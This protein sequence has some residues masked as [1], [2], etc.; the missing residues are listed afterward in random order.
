VKGEGKDKLSLL[1]G[2]VAEAP[3]GPGVY[4]MRDGEGKV[5]YVG[6]AKDLRA[7]LRSYLGADTRPMIPFLVSRVRDVDF[8]VTATEKE[9]LILENN[10]IK[11]HRPRYNIDF[12]DD[13]AYF[14]IRI[15]PS[16]HVPSLRLQRRPKKDGARYF[17]PYPSSAA[18]KEALDFLQQA[19]GLRVCSDRELRARKRPCL[20]FEI[21]R[22]RG[23]CRGLV[24]EEDYRRAVADAVAFLEG[25]EGRLIAALE[26][27]MRIAAAAER[28]EEAA[29]LRDRLKALR[30][31]IERQRVTSLAFGDGD[32][33]G[34]NRREGVTQV[35]LLTVRGGRLT[36][37]ADLPLIRLDM[38]PAAVMAAVL[39]R[40]YDEGVS[41][42]PR[43]ILPVAPEGREVL[44]DWLRDRRGGK[45]TL[46][47]PKR[48]EGKALLEMACRNAE[49]L[50]AARLASAGEMER[51]LE[52]AAALLDLKVIP[53]R[54][55]CFDISDLGGRQAVG[56]R[57]VFVD[58]APEKGSYRRWRVHAVTEGD[59]YAMIS[60]VLRRRFSR[61][62]PHPDLVIV[63]GG[64]GHLRCALAVMRELG[65]KGQAVV[66]IAKGPGAWD[67]TETDRVY[68]PGRR[69]AVSLRRHPSVLHLFQH[70]RDEAHRFAV[71][72]HRRLRER[73]GMGSFLDGVPGI[74]E[75]RKRALLRAFSGPE[76]ML[77]AGVEGLA[78]AARM[79]RK[80]A[81]AVLERLAGSKR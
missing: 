2:K 74:G 61:E 7:R 39:Q 47:V 41:I 25:R 78:K 16:S 62:E 29:V 42:P 9:A 80:T 53:R 73:E 79:G 44:S 14:H 71:S 6:K 49:E 19:F 63:D 40:R 35:C 30:G 24:R 67:A 52:E 54:M 57:A 20:E 28:F 21:G 77:K 34:M 72:Y 4:L 3:R 22:C 69:D 60:E 68:L 70:I 15:D 46:S 1:R 66:A 48:G 50:L 59:D 58:G 36:G 12:R 38:E 55:E 45:V 27:E 56:A 23:P 64:K 51:T 5:L 43:I 26:E 81:A 18:A 75:A 13:R 37:R 11:E 10:L 65:V 32:V 8:I 17:G 33:Y 31:V 76:E